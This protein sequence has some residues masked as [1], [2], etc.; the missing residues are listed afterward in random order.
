M[1]NIF[2]V[3]SFTTDKTMLGRQLRLAAPMGIQESIIAVGWSVFYKIMGMVG[4]VELATTQL[5]FTIMHASFMPALGVGQACS[6]LVSKY[7]GEKQIEKSESS[8][9]ES[10]RLAEYIMSVMGLS[11]IFFPK[12]YLFLFTND[13]EIIKFGVF[14]LRII[15]AVQFLD[16][17]GFVLWF[18]LSG[19]GN[20]VFPAVVE[21]LL[22]WVV[23]VFGSYFFGI[24]LEMG[25]K[26][27][28]V[29]FPI[30]MGLFA[31]IMVWKINQGDWKNIEV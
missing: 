2:S 9:K 31:G 1:K 4:L 8:I 18:A 6:T 3:L 29:L 16:A 25:F 20:T 26:A 19:A 17:I 13:P 12:F 5:L 23:I 10:I 27:P 15:G 7:M 24:V 28:W 21:S 14:G 11:F 30:Y 22:V